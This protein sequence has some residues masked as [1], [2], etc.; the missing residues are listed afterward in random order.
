[1]INNLIF[2]SA[3]A[4]V[5]VPSTLKASVSDRSCGGLV[6]RGIA[7]GGALTPARA[8]ILIYDSFP[9]WAKASLFS[10]IATRVKLY[11]Y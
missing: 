10:G 6:R 9:G 3:S 1:M 7:A 11:S 5:A 4:T 2:S 8:T